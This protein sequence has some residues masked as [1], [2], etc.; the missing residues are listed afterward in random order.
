MTELERQLTVALERSSAQRETEQRRHSE[1]IE[2][3]RQQVEALQ[4]Q[5]E[6]LSEQV[7]RLTEYYG[8]FGAGS[9]AR[10]R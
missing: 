10:W 2:A 7:T 4:R 1:Q 8:T 5:V 9:L 6:R 3:L